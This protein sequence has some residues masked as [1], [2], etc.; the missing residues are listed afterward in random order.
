MTMT[1][2]EREDWIKSELIDQLVESERFLT[3][4]AMNY[5]VTQVVDDEAKS[6][7]IQLIEV[8]FAVATERIKTEAKKRLGEAEGAIQVVG[9]GALDAL[10]RGV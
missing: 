5:D 3:F 7:R 10:K 8:P 9:A 6:V 4:L 1:P 2:E